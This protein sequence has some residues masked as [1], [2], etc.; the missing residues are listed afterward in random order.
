MN[1]KNIRLVTAESVRAGHPDK[2]CDQVADAILD[3]HLRQDPNARVAVEVFATAGKI[4]VGGEI[5]SKVEV[6]YDKIVADVI[7]RIGYTMEDLCENPH[8]LL[9]LEVCLH[10]QSPDISA[11]VDKT[12]LGAGDQGIM[13]GYASNET[14][15]LMP[16]T[17]VYAHK[18]V[19]ELARLRKTQP[20]KYAFLRPDSKSQVSMRYVD[21]KPVS[22]EAV[23]VSHQH[24]P[25]MKREELEKLVKEVVKKV[26]PAKYLKGKVQYH[27]NPTGRFVVGGPN[28][29][30]GL[31]GRKIIV[32]TYGG[33]CPHGGGAFSGKD[34]S[35]VDRSA[36]Y[37]ARY[38]AKNIVAAGLAKKC[39]IQ[40]SYAIGVARPIN[41]TINT[42]GTGVIADSKIAALVND[43]FDLRPKGIVQMLDLLHP[44]YVKTAAYGHFGRDEPEFTWEKTD[45]A[46][47]LR[48]AAGL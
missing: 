45:K 32:D 16:A 23:V 29:D 25:E 17:I 24:T 15:E 30:T 47:D 13:V 31:T 34:P 26:I 18:I 10:E 27:I 40:V 39:Q 5:T 1:E 8:D 33:S 9:E 14:K 46:A 41:I 37:A 42:E 48:Q 11:A 36:A 35:K 20:K 6:P 21:G 7:N 43:H 28:G 38:V 19:Q 4:V 3:A 12:E 2:F 44:R 22:V